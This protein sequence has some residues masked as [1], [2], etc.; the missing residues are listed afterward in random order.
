MELLPIFTSMQLLRVLVAAVVAMVVGAIRFGPLFGKVYMA[1]MNV[2]PANMPQ[3]PN[4][5]GN[6]VKEFITRLIYFLGLLA[7]L[8]L[9]GATETFAA[10]CV[11]AFSYRLAVISTEISGVIRSDF[12]WRMAA[13]T[14]GKILV[15]TVLALIIAGRML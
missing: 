9:T 14:G 5:A 3:K 10:S 12:S 8:L 4:M 15:D 1:E 13:V 7:L 6:M 2:D 11:V